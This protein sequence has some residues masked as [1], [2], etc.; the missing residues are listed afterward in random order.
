MRIIIESNASKPM[1][2]AVIVHL[3][4]D[5]I[6]SVMTRSAVVMWLGG[7]RVDMEWGNESDSRRRER[8]HTWQFQ[9]QGPMVFFIDHLKKEIDAVQKALS[10]TTKTIQEIPLEDLP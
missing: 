6:C 8:R 10:Q 4:F 3:P 1:G 9:E 2:Y 7:M 5:W